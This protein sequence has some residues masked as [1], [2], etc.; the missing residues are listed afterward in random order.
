MLTETLNALKHLLWPDRCASCDRL[1]DQPNTSLC[2][3]CHDAL[4]F[5]GQLPPPTGIASAFAFFNH[6]GPIQSMVAKWKYH[7]DY[8]AQHALLQCAAQHLTSLKPWLPPG[9]F[10]PVPP[11]PR[12]L[13]TRGFDPVW[14]FAQK[15]TAMLHSSDVPC[16][17]LEDNLLSRVIHTPHQAG[18][19]AEARRDNLRGAFKVNR[20][21][22]H[23]IIL[24]DDVLTTGA[25]AT[26]CA[27]ALT[28]HGAH[29]VY[30]LTLAHAHIGADAAPSHLHEP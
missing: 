25:T 27:E 9:I 28:L 16:I 3:P 5:V 15:L 2:A 22:K 30:L 23:T 14:T 8:A 11:H 6:D 17:A 19:S 26:A 4:Q 10:V 24:V 1:I 7:E 21:C 13:Q 29:A 18:L 20:P 12:R